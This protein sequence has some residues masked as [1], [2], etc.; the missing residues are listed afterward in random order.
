MENPKDTWTTVLEV[1]KRIH[2][3]NGTKQNTDVVLSVRVVVRER[4]LLLRVR[5]ATAE[6]LK[7]HSPCKCK[8]ERTLFRSLRSRQNSSFRTRNNTKVTDGF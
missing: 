8:K 4:D 2:E 7:H 3:A 6:F 5:N 1:F